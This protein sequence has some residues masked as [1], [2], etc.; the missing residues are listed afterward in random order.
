MFGQWNGCVGRSQKTRLIKKQLM[1]AW[2]QESGIDLIATNK[3]LFPICAVDNDVVK[4]HRD[5][6][7]LSSPVVI[8]SLVPL[9]IIHVRI[10]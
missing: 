7:R 9:T 3:G 1:P 10:Q 6:H 4:R 8:F 5:G 2:P